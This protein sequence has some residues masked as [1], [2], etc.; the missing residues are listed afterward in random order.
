MERQPALDSARRTRKPSPRSCV[1]GERER[2]IISIDPE[3]FV[4][5]LEHELSHV[6]TCTHVALHHGAKQAAS[7]RTQGKGENRQRKA[8]EL[9]D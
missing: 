8:L 4:F 2:S 1:G 3:R 5:E 9:F 7:M 6:L